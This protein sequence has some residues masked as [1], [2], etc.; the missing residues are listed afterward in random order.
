MGA[1]ETLQGRVG[2]ELGRSGWL[3]VDQERVDRHAD[4]TGDAQWIHNDPARAAA[5]GPFGGPIAQGFLLLSLFTA[6]AEQAMPQAD[7]LE[8]LVNYGFDRVRFIR[9]VR[10]GDAVRLRVRLADVS[11]NPGGRWIVALDAE[12]ESREAADAA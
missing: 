11:Q 2:Q 7:G 10:V 5:E 8:Y 1:V 6:L 3:M 12:L 9:P 4:N